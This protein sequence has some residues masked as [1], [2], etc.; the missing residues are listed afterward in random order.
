L[1]CSL[2]KLIEGD[3]YFA[4]ELSKNYPSLSFIQFPHFFPSDLISCIQFSTTSGSF[5]GP[6]HNIPNFSKLNSSPRVSS[7][8]EAL[9]ICSQILFDEKHSKKLSETDPKEWSKI[10]F[11]SSNGKLFQQLCEISNNFPPEYF[12]KWFPTK[13]TSGEELKRELC[14]HP[15]QALV[16][17]FFS[18][19]FQQV[20]NQQKEW[21]LNQ[22]LSVLY[23]LLRARILQEEKYFRDPS[24]TRIQ[25]FSW[26]EQ[27]K[28]VLLS[29]PRNSNLFGYRVSILLGSDLVDD[30][31]AKIARKML[32][33]I[34][35]IPLQVQEYLQETNLHQLIFSAMK[36]FSQNL[37]ENSSVSWDSTPLL[38]IPQFL[39]YYI[40]LHFSRTSHYNSMFQHNLSQSF[41]NLTSDIINKINSL[42]NPFNTQELIKKNDEIVQSINSDI[43]KAKDIAKNIVDSIS[44][45]KRVYSNQ[46]TQLSILYNDGT[47]DFY[48]KNHSDQLQNLKRNCNEI[49][50]HCNPKE[51][52]QHQKI[53]QDILEEYPEFSLNFQYS[54]FTCDPLKVSI[55]NIHQLNKCIKKIIPFFLPLNPMIFNQPSLPPIICNGS[56]TSS[57]VDEFN[58]LVGEHHIGINFLLQSM[59][60]DFGVFIE[61]ASL[62]SCGVILIENLSNNAVNISLDNEQRIGL[63]PQLKSNQVLCC[64]KIEISFSFENS[65]FSP[66]CL[67]SYSCQIIAESTLNQTV[68]TTCCLKVFVRRSPLCT[69]IESSSSFVIHDSIYTLAPE[70]YTEFIHLK[71][72]FPKSLLSSHFFSFSLSSERENQAD[73]PEVE[74]TDS[75]EGAIRMKFS[76]HTTGRCVGNLSVGLGRHI[77]YT[78]PLNIFVH[79][80]QSLGL[81]HPANRNSSEIPLEKCAETFIIVYNW[82]KFSQI[83]HLESSCLDDKIEPNSFEI[84]SQSSSIVKISFGDF[85]SHTISLGKSRLVFRLPDVA[86]NVFR[87]SD[88]AL[89]V[90]DSKIEGQNNCFVHCCIIK[91]DGS[92][93]I[94]YI[95]SYNFNEQDFPIIITQT[96]DRHTKTPPKLITNKE[97]IQKLKRFA[98]DSQNGLTSIDADHPSPPNMFLLWAEDSSNHSFIR[99]IDLD[100]NQI[101]KLSKLFAL[102]YSQNQI[103]SSALRQSFLDA[104]NSFF[105]PKRISNLQIQNLLSFSKERRDYF[106]QLLQSLDQC[107]K[108][109]VF[110]SVSEIVSSIACLATRRRTW[111]CQ[112]PAFDLIFE[113]P[114]DNPE[115]CGVS[116]VFGTLVLLQVLYHPFTP[117]HDE[118]LFYRMSY[119]KNLLR[120]FHSIVLFKDKNQSKQSKEKQFNVLVLFQENFVKLLLLRK[121]SIKFRL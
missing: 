78:L 63:I 56:S 111:I 117:T 40:Y 1:K 118:I 18:F 53:C 55:S 103:S 19:E 26:K 95:K 12:P 9:I 25:H 96:E 114:I 79:S 58:I 17:Q 49:L 115:I 88:V 65:T 30:L 28:S 59:T 80:I 97:D 91:S 108:N 77:L 86:L 98:L 3:E 106:S 60:A 120:S 71:H 90:F 36:S 110:S 13:E 21:N 54:H 99:V 73:V 33:Q 31:E 7:I 121:F 29:I 119:Q 87:L 24:P 6:F 70:G 100:G 57:N 2:A 41:G 52:K 105:T 10:Q 93:E 81:Y 34:I 76:T 38:N 16:H 75:S 83:A 112:A 39:M 27:W 51:Y 22:R 32:N 23:V 42:R 61:S 92:F 14:E 69:I 72:Q 74:I 82:S 11:P 113:L 116:L 102:I 67:C 5:N 48:F 94:S 64:E 109:N 35:N 4:D 47:L 68:K 66:P 15:G 84:S 45:S 62:E 44:G 107:L 37:L 85:V 20:F 8:R 89:N 46:I 43:D 50:Q 104:V 101:Q